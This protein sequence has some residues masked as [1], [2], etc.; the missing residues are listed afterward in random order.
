MKRRL[1]ILTA[2]LVLA[3][4]ATPVMASQG[5]A[6]AVYTVEGADF[7]A[8]VS[9][10]ATSSAGIIA[11]AVKD[12]HAADHPAATDVSAQGSQG[13][14]PGDHGADARQFGIDVS[15][16]AKEHP[17]EVADLAK[18][19]HSDGHPTVDAAGA[20]GSAPGASG[21]HATDGRSFG[22]TVADDAPQ[23][24]RTVAHMVA[25]DHAGGHTTP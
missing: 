21:D 4:I 7:G 16:I 24:P 14:T 23:E 25:N 19:S 18:N 5:G 9:E 10:Q 6:R 15:E 2:V 12:T 20:H 3:A 1:T 17:S 13:D 8:A 22:A 11:E